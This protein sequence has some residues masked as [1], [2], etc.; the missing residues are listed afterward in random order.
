MFCWDR[1]DTKEEGKMRYVLHLCQEPG[2]ELLCP[3]GTGFSRRHA[4]R[5]AMTQEAALLR[6]Y[7]HAQ[8]GVKA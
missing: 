2:Y 8:L 6:G 7:L 3:T 4:E 1:L 5:N